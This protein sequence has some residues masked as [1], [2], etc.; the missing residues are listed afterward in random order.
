ML[1]KI[2]SWLDERLLLLKQRVLQLLQGANY[3]GRFYRRRSQTHTHTY[4]R[5]HMHTHTLTHKHDNI[6]TYVCIIHNYI[7]KDN[8]RI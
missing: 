7:F 5:T 3:I 4:T 8:I 6:F 1:N 2:K